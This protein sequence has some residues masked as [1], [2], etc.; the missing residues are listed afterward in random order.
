MEHYQ[1]VREKRAQLLKIFS[2]AVQAVEGRRCVSSFLQ[3]HELPTET[4]HVVAIGKAASSMMQGAQDILGQR[5]H[6]GLVITKYQHGTPLPAPI[7]MIEAAHPVSDKNSLLAG[8]ALCDFIQMCPPDRTLLVLLSGGASALVEVLPDGMTLE[9]LAAMS[10]WLLSQPLTIQQINAVRKSVSRI[11]DGKLLHYLQTPHCYQLLL[12]DV[13][14]NELSVIGSGLLADE[15][16]TR[17]DIELPQWIDDLIN[18]QR[19]QA[20]HAHQTVRHF[21]L[22]DHQTLCV[23]ARN[24]AQSTG[25]VVQTEAI[26]TGDAEKFAASAIQQMMQGDSGIYI[27]GGETYLTLPAQPGRGGRCQQMALRAAIELAGNEHMVLLAGA[28]DGTDGPGDV[29]GAVI[30]GQTISRGKDAGLDANVCLRHADSGRFLEAS[31]D[32]IDTGPTGTN[33]NDLVLGLKWAW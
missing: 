13:P 23:A 8:K 4:L 10:Q 15:K 1:Q 25:L 11:K 27:W 31:G 18:K 17:I 21:I 24:A 12:S 9:Q 30:D 33:V 28:S 29:A 6:A 14:G 32:L 2:D 26:M 22:A 7:K 19:S 16:P 3:S 20:V 5:I